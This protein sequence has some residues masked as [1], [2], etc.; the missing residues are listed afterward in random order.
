MCVIDRQCNISIHR[1]M[2]I[3]WYVGCLHEIKNQ[4]FKQ[5]AK[6]RLDAYL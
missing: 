3:H 2:S 6:D 5:T 1:N 4:I